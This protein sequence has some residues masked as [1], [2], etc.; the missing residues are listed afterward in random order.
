MHISVN[1]HTSCDKFHRTMSLYSSHGGEN[2]KKFFSLTAAFCLVFSLTTCA[3]WREPE[4]DYLGMML[5]A[6][7]Q[8][9]LQAGHEAQELYRLQA[10]EKGE[11]AEVSFDELY[12]LSRAIHYKYG[13][14]RYSD[15]LRMCAGEVILNRMA[16]PEYPDSMEA[17]IFQ[18]G[19]D[20][21]IE[22]EDFEQ[23]T[24]PSQACVAVACRLL[25]GER[26][27][28]PDVVL[29]SHCPDKNIYAMFCDSLLGN[30]YF[31]KSEHP[32]LY[33]TGN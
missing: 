21:G 19:Q 28:E 17:V 15:E 29:E 31:F 5:Q 1:F 11:T 13:H 8:G 20:T 22:P 14:Y 24:C 30:T 3:R 2:V 12:L 23:C 27:L 33:K 25:S 18:P 26:M 7:Q 32:E 16:S 4:P 10:A 9:D 6:A